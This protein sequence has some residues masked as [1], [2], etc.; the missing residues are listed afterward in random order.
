MGCAEDGPMNC[1]GGPSSN[2][3]NASSGR[4]ISY[5]IN[6]EGP[7]DKSTLGKVTYVSHIME[8]TQKAKDQTRTESTEANSWKKEG[9][10]MDSSSNEGIRDK[11]EA[12]KTKG[13]GMSVEISKVMEEGV[14]RGYDFNAIMS[15]KTLR[16]LE[17]SNNN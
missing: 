9:Q 2:L 17:A 6:P 4:S 14:V 12:F 5:Q 3:S 1:F 16:E 15:D 11:K 13:K 8:L 7:V 10:I